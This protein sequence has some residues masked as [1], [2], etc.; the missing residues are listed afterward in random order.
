MGH[1]VCSLSLLCLL[2]EHARVAPAADVDPGQVPD[3]NFR[4]V[5]Q[6]GDGGDARDDR[7]RPGNYTSG[8]S[9]NG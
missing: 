8:K 9:L 4:R 1:P 3:G 5:R 7:E 2:L 6:R